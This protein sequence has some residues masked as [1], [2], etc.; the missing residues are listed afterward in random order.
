MFYLSNDIENI[1]IINESSGSGEI[2]KFINYL[3]NLSYEQSIKNIYLYTKGKNDAT[4]L[5]KLYSNIYPQAIIYSVGGDGTLNEIVNGINPN[6]RLAIIPLGTGNDFYKIYKKIK[7]TQKIDIGIVNDKKFINIASLGLDAEIAKKAN[8]YKL[9]KKYKHNEYSVGIIKTLMENP[10]YSTSIGNLSLLA[11]CNGMYYGNGVPINPNYNLND[12]NFEVYSANELT[13]LQCIKLFLKIFT[14]SHYNNDLVSYYKSSDI[15]VSS[16]DYLMCN[17][18]GEIIYA[19]E[20]EFKNIKDGLTITTDVPN[21]I[22]Q[23]ML[24][25]DKR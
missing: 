23:Y 3:Y 8:K 25:R 2:K 10:H 4:K 7:G 6:S 14:A 20:F 13:R 16:P 19:K 17:I 18:D 24:N 1:Y 9:L 12:G 21:Y 15:V 11:I 22:H 5:A